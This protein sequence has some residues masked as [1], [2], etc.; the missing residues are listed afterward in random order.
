MWESEEIFAEYLEN[1]GKSW[2]YEPIRFELSIKTYVPDF[3]CPEDDIFYEVDSGT[4]ALNA[5]KDKINLFK[6]EYP[7]IK[8]KVV[9]PGGQVVPRVR[10]RYFLSRSMIDMSWK[11]KLGEE[12]RVRPGPK[13]NYTRTGIRVVATLP[14]PLADEVKK[15]AWSHGVSYQVFIKAALVEYVKKYGV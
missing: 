4:G 3:Y 5:K 6:K 2:A 1:Q 13:T 8:F 9:T 10:D 15:T 14:P 11:A 12:R 7:N